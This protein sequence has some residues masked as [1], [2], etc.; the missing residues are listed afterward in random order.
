MDFFY[1][2]F[3]PPDCSL[4]PQTIQNN[5]TE[6]LIRISN[7]VSFKKPGY[8]LKA[9]IVE[10]DLITKNSKIYM[11]DNIKKVSATSVLK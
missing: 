4:F 3:F 5:R 2:L 7:N 1:K 11:K 8:S 6:N 9:D 10:I